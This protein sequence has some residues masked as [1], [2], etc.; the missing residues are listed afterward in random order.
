MRSMRASAKWIMLVVAVAFVGWM[1]FDV[2]GLTGGGGGLGTSETVLRVNG[3][4]LDY[5]SF[6]LAVRDAQER[7]RIQFGSGPV[8][9]DDYR[10]LEDAVVEEF[11]RDVMFNQEYRRRGITVS[12]EEILA[13]AENSPP[14]EVI[15]L[16]D[17]QTEGQFDLA[18]YQRY[19]AA[20]ADPQFLLALET[21]YR[22]EIPRVKLFEQLSIDV[23]VPDG[24]LWRLYRDEHDSAVVVVVSVR[25]AT[26]IGDDAISLGDADLARYYRMHE[27]EYRR[28]AKAFLSHVS[29][30]KAVNTSDSAAAL[31]AA[32]D[33]YERVTLG[34]AGGADFAGMARIESADSATRAD[35]GNLGEAR[36]GRF[37]TTFEAA[38]L[39]LNPGE[40]AE[41]VL[42]PGG[43]HIIRLDSRS[44]DSYQV[45][46]ILVAVE[47]RG[48]HLQAVES[49]ADS[50]DIFG[51]EQTDPDA[52]DDVAA[53]LDLTVDRVSVFEGDRLRL[54]EGPVPDAGMW[55]FETREGETSLV[56][57]T[58]SGYHLFR[59][60]SIVPEHVPPLAEIQSVVR[61]RAL[62]QAKVD[63][64]TAALGRLVAE[65]GPD[66]D[67]GEL[68]G[69]PGFSVAT[70]GP[71]TRN[72]PGFELRDL[73]E[74]VGSVFGKREG[75]ALGPFT[76]DLGTVFI[77][78]PVRRWV[79][80]SS[81][82]VAQQEAQ[83]EAVTAR[84]RDVRIR[85]YLAALR[86][87]VK[88]IDRRR[89]IEELQRQL[90]ESGGFPGIP[91]GF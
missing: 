6:L 34:G 36:T 84:E 79:A 40:I 85:R 8:T 27:D 90:A 4:K 72:N 10:R 59:L 29:V 82:F 22:T 23:Y 73:P 80:D 20:G 60:D 33:I 21:R 71:I 56:I 2:A 77:A 70:V 42:S 11:V 17:F 78:K 28:P 57:E 18:K 32:R 45:S 3:V 89:E 5:Q 54:A 39:G 76:N 37:H 7:Q 49:L 69:R 13:A 53:R 65:M 1:V 75:T 15:Q 55:A 25:S 26:A 68:A 47:L 24:R 74:L 87:E 61:A 81:T 30:S 64:V 14:P 48:E 51:A 52:L 19:L 50:L 44:A 66:P 43:Y 88:V 38:A 12:D 31:A 58:D 67:L 16:P 41:P 63:T 46:H 9:L 86:Q 91:G 83:R 35:G 62:L